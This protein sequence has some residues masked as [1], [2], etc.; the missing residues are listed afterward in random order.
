MSS[1]AS[2]L[3]HQRET[4][5]LIEQQ[6]QRWLMLQHVQ[7]R[8]PVGQPATRGHYI[9]ISRE[10]GA[11]GEQIGRAVSEELGWRV[12]DRE[13]LTL[14]AQAAS[15]SACDIESVDE[16][17]MRW[18]TELFNHWVDHGP[19]SHEKYLLCLAAVL[20]AATRQESVV[21]VGRGAQFLLPRE[22]GLVVRIVAPERF[23]VEQVQR[24]RGLG[25]RE[26]RAWV[27]RTDRER[28]QFIEQH[29]HHDGCDMHL[30]DM[31]LNVE[32]LGM[33]GAA[34]QI[35]QAARAAFGDRVG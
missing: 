6:I 26:A 4:S 11:G 22:A 23:R 20:R 18:I 31:V 29:F 35:A 30:Y 32:K 34:R 14:V 27:E 8:R 25:A 28:R 1:L 12:L 2:S 7:Q 19:V 9:A 33:A 15:C 13:L 21:I 24:V 16:T 17:G 10:A 5:A 3:R